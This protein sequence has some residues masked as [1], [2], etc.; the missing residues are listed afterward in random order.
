MSVAAAKPAGN[1]PATS[2]GALSGPEKSKSSDFA[3]QLLRISDRPLLTAFIQ[4][5]FQDCSKQGEAY[6]D[7]APFLKAVLAKINSKFSSTV[8]ASDLLEL[9]HE[10][11]TFESTMI[12]I[13]YLEQMAKKRARPEDDA[14]LLQDDER[15][16]MPRRQDMP[17]DKYV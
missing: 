6:P 8:N 9:L 7:G 12:K 15:R 2:N 1:D 4:E 5:V 10:E 14:G 17:E 16:V 11:D 13:S 3:G